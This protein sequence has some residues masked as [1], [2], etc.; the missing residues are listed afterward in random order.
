MRLEGG[1]QMAYRSDIDRFDRLMGWLAWAT[2]PALPLFGL[3]LLGEATGL[4]PDEATIAFATLSAIYAAARGY[5]GRRATAA[6]PAASRVSLRLS[7][8]PSAAALVRVS[9]TRRWVSSAN[10]TLSS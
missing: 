10:R 4:V 6:Y 8:S 7:H 3:L 9:S 1:A 5:L 2:A